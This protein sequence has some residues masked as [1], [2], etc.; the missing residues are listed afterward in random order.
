MAIGKK[1][2]FPLSYTSDRKNKPT[3]NLEVVSKAE[4]E[5]TGIAGC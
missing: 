4:G 3:P 5:T 2:E 1:V